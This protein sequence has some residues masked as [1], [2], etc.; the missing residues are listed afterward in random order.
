MAGMLSDLVDYVRVETHTVVG[1]A[2][3]ADT[4]TGKQRLIDH[5]IRPAWAELLSLLGGNDG[6]VHVRWPITLASGTRRYA[7]PP[8]IAHIREFVRYDDTKDLYVV[9][10]ILPE[11]RL[12]AGFT[13]FGWAKELNELYLGFDPEAYDAESWDLVFVPSGDF[14]V[15]EG[16]TTTFTT[17]TIT[18]AASPTLGR[19]DPQVNAYVGAVIR[20]V[21]AVGQPEQTRVI[22][23]YDATTR[24][25]TVQSDFS[26]ALAGTETYDI[27]P[28]LWTPSS[29]QAVGM[30]AARN[31]MVGAGSNAK[32]S[33]VALA[34]DHATQRVQREMRTLQDRVAFKM[35]PQTR[36]NYPVWNTGLLPGGI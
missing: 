10:E 20:I 21:D 9:N 36:D 26:P 3:F 16:S 23:A 13:T 5:H 33:R 19:L 14:S 25:A 30:I 1:Q 7:I 15:H 12:A 31:L 28:Y 22:T 34:A 35:N 8:N 27:V 6:E 2:M 18:L 4:A 32:F 11:D 24:V 29:Q 17:N